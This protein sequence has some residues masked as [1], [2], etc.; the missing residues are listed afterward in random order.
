MQRIPFLI[1]GVRCSRALRRA[2]AERPRTHRIRKPTPP[3]P[4]GP[5]PPADPRA[6]T[7][8]GLA[9]PNITPTGDP[10]R[11][12]ASSPVGAHDAAP[13]THQSDP[14][15][16]SPRSNTVTTSNNAFDNPAASRDPH[17]SSLAANVLAI[18]A[19]TPPASPIVTV[20][21][22]ASNASDTDCPG[23]KGSATAGK[24]TAPPI[25]DD[26]KGRRS[27]RPTAVSRRPARRNRTAARAARGDRPERPCQRARHIH[28]VVATC[29][30]CKGDPDA[31]QA[32]RSPRHPPAI[33]EGQAR[34]S[35]PRRRLTVGR[36][37]ERV[38]LACAPSSSLAAAARAVGPRVLSPPPYPG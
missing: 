21:R 38:T 12:P 8:L 37:C 20:S 26:L 25:A 2:I 6:T 31:L 9:R 24:T 27:T 28:L 30:D 10:G 18:P 14:A 15:V 34:R 23:A 32:P 1:R 19:W 22:N 5:V 16:W 7:L 17:R 29:T 13:L 36:R 3:G 33:W 4:R 11:S 35:G